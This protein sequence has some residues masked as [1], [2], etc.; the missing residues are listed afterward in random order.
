MLT[1]TAFVSHSVTSSNAYK[2][3][4]LLS[5]PALSADFPVFDILEWGPSV[6][7]L[8]VQLKRICARAN[9]GQSGEGLRKRVDS[10]AI[11]ASGGE[12][13]C[14]RVVTTT[15]AKQGGGVGACRGGTSRGRCGGSGGGSGGIGGEVCC[16]QGLQLVKSGSE[17]VLNP[18]Q[19]VGII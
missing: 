6:S 8:K 16:Y 13:Q 1:V 11:S 4:I 2:G 18:I 12:A 3:G 14:R 17:D 5:S 9:G 19:P 7:A 10:S 15:C